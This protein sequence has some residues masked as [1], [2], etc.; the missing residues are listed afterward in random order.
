MANSAGT[1]NCLMCG[2]SART[3]ATACAHCGARLATVACPGCFGMIFQGSHYCPLCG[4]RAN[5]VVGAESKLGCPHC[6]SPLTVITV[7]AAALNECGKCEG[8]W[9]DTV[10]FDRICAEREEQMAILG[11]AIV[12]PKAEPSSKIKYIKCPECRVLMHRVNFAGSSGVVIDICRSHGAWFDARELQRI[13]DFIRKGGMSRA[14]EKQA[15][16]LVR[17]RRDVAVERMG[18]PMA[19]PR[20]SNHSEIFDLVGMVGRLVLHLLR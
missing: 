17:A 16:D 13:V 10:S 11:P 19:I 3:D 6:E 4:V 7:G 15:A 18:S 2:A 12:L 1:L 14:R 9:V 5:R 8:L 20:G